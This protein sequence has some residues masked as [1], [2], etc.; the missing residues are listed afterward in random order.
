MRLSIPRK[1]AAI[2]A[3]ALALPLTACSSTSQSVG[4]ESVDSLVSRVEAV[5]LETELAKQA[6]YNALI[7][8]GPLVAD[9]FQGDPKEAFAAFAEQTVECERRA[10]A[11]RGEVVP[12]TNSAKKVFENWRTSL[13]DFASPSMR[14]RSQR[15]LDAT[16]DRFAA[17]NDAATRAQTDFD[18]VNRRL[19]DVVLFLG[20]DFNAAAVAEVREEALSIRDEARELGKVFDDCMTAAAEYVETSALRGQVQEEGAQPAQAKDKKAKGQ[21]QDG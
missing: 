7:T 4:I 8:L 19:R 17:V 21:G 9:E 1:S 11:L 20:H 3:L 10:N 16:R 14:E 13:S 5:H 2:A 6:V 12:M 15:R 18:E